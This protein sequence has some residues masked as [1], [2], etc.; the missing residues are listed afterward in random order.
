MRK[1]NERT[2]GLILLSIGERNLLLFEVQQ[3]FIPLFISFRKKG[4][5]RETVLEVERHRE[6]TEKNAEK[7]S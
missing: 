3:I 7:E 5:V 4:S 1:K 2:K 6:E